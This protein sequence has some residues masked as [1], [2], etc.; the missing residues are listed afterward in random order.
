MANTLSKLVVATCVGTTLASVINTSPASAVQFNFSAEFPKEGSSPGGILTGTFSAKDVDNDKAI[1][2][3]FEP[4]VDLITDFFL[5][6]KS[7][8]PSVFPSFTQ[9]GAE[10]LTQ[11]NF[12]LNNPPGS[13]FDF[14]TIGANVVTPNFGEV[15]ISLGSFDPKTFL[16]ASC[17]DCGLEGI[18]GG[19]LTFQPVS[20]DVPESSSVIGL[21]GL[22]LLGLGG[23]AKKKI[24]ASSAFRF[25]RSQPE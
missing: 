9:S 11:V 10:L 18:E 22:T 13:G 7:N 8:N 21:M 1:T 24:K 20:Q 16:N 4:D 5:E 12:D 2:V 23:L 17:D 25:H 14:N 3:G 15:S 6:F 19:V